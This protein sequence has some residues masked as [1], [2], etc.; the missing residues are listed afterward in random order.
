MKSWV[1]QPLI[2]LAQASQWLYSC[3]LAWFF[4]E[5]LNGAT[6]EEECELC[7]QPI[8]YQLYHLLY[9]TLWLFNIAMV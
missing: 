8:I 9:D 5:G 2:D 3:D 4:S 6:A 1:E 7:S